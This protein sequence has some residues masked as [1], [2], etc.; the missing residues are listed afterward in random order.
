[1]IG[2]FGKKIRSMRKARGMT[3]A[4]LG[5][6]AGVSASYVSQIE[7]GLCS[8][9]LASLEQI[10]KS[11]G[12]SAKYFFYD[13]DEYIGS[14][15]NLASNYVCPSDQQYF[16]RIISNDVG[17]KKIRVYE[18][19]IL[20]CIDDKSLDIRGTGFLHILSGILTLEFNGETERMFHGD[21]LF[22]DGTINY[23]FFNR[24]NRLVNLLYVSFEKDD[25]GW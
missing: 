8:V 25:L 15:A 12:V 18:V 4:E 7:R 5:E 1:M 17:G 3:L 10:A 19:S 6:A 20:P 9:S 22:C 13:D 2:N 24:S 23:R 16:Y 14:L 11:L 21:S